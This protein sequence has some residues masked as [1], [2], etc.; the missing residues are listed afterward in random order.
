MISEGPQHASIRESGVDS[1]VG[2]MDGKSL[3]AKSWFCR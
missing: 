1:Y 2:V 3:Y